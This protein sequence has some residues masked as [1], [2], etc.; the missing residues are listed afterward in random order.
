LTLALGARHPVLA[1]LAIAYCAP[2]HALIDA[3]QGARLFGF[4]RARLRE[5]QFEGDGIEKIAL[6]FASQSIERALG[7]ADIAPLLEEGAALT[8]DDALALLVTPS[9]VGVVLTPRQDAG[10]NGVV[11]LLD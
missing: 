1:N 2:A 8:Q 6:Q 4:A 10:D 5:I 9:T 3:Q 7:T 11:T